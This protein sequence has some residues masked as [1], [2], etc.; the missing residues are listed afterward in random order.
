MQLSA[1]SFSRWEL[2]SGGGLIVQGDVR[3]AMVL[4]GNC[5]GGN[6]PVPVVAENVI[7][8]Y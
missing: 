2:S 8:S 7:K 1:G 6:C 3:G 5:P 4:D